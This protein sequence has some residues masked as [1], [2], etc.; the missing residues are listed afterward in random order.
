MDDLDEMMKPFGWDITCCG[1]A[2]GDFDG[3]P[4]AMLVEALMAL[5]RCTEDGEDKVVM[6]RLPP[7][8]AVAIIKAF[9]TDDPLS[10]IQTTIA[11]W[12]PAWMKNNPDAER[13]IAIRQLKRRATRS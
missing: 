2:A 9:E 1:S 6:F 11:D 8:V 4:K 10:Y 7:A 12:Q 13:A 5:A 3:T